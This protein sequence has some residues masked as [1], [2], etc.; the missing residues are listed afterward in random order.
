MLCMEKFV[1]KYAKS[2]KQTFTQIDLRDIKDVMIEQDPHV[3]NKNRGS[4][5]LGFNFIIFTTQRSYRMQAPT[6][7]VQIM[8][9]KAFSLWFELQAYAEQKDIISQSLQLPDNRPQILEDATSFQ[10]SIDSESVINVFNEGY[11]E[12]T[13]HAKSQIL[14]V[15][16]LE[17]TK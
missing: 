16:K 12:I 4:E 9:L 2:P 6:K 3:T 8:W 17:I 7:A 1:F 10:D 13:K 15:K 14:E 11:N 5:R